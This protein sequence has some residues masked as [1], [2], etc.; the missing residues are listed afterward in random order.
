MVK[1]YDAYTDISVFP[2]PAITGEGDCFASFSSLMGLSF[3]CCMVLV[4][5]KA[6]HTVAFVDSLTHVGDSSAL[7]YHDLDHHL[8]LALFGRLLNH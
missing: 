4:L 3:A 6:D 8:V 5:H 2:V 1:H 7:A